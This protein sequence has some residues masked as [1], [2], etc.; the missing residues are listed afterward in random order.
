MAGS[1]RSGGPPTPNESTGSATSPAEPVS[2]RVGATL[3]S[4]ARLAVWAMTFIE[5]SRGLP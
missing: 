2:I 4:G 1:A 3:P 5:P